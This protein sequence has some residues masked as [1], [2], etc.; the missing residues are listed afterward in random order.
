MIRFASFEAISLRRAIGM[1]ILKICRPRPNL[2]KK[3]DAPQWIVSERVPVRIDASVCLVP[4]VNLFVTIVEARGQRV[5][6]EGN[7]EVKGYRQKVKE[8]YQ[9]FA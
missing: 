1:R 7:T 2:K 9:R 8:Q 4:V 5:I 3:T 6:E